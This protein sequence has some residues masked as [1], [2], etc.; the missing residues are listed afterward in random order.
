MSSGRPGLSDAGV[1]DTL[2]NKNFLLGFLESYDMDLKKSHEII[3]RLNNKE[4]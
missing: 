1:W 4:E 2:S 3:L